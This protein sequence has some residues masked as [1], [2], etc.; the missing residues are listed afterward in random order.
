MQ[1]V[2][3]KN[4]KWDKKSTYFFLFVIVKKQKIFFFI[5]FY[6]YYQQF[7]LSKYDTSFWYSKSL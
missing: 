2:E 3:V 1:T 7:P 6:L 4:K 5:V